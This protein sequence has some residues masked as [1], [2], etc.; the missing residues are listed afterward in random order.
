MVIAYRLSTIRS[1]DLVVALDAGQLLKRR[2]LAGVLRLEPEE[3]RTRGA[4]QLLGVVLEAEQVETFALTGGYLG[5]LAAVELAAATVTLAA[6]ARGRLLVAT[7]AVWVALAVT[8]SR[9]GLRRRR[10]WTETRLALTHDLVERLVGHRTRLA[11][12]GAAIQQLDRERAALAGYA[13][14]SRR[15]DRADAALVAFVPRGWVAAG[16]AALVLPSPAVLDPAGLAIGVGGVLLGWQALR[17]L[18]LGLSQLAGAAVAF[19]RLAPLARA[20]RRPARTSLP[21]AAPRC[22]M[23]AT[24]GSPIPAAPVRCWTV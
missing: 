13:E 7:L 22:W 8:L 5:L 18:T 14:R 17:K 15:L 24:S 9:V 21:G 23:L 19:Q 11:F 6:G 1:A 3:I 20:A 16:A 2:L 12:E 4:G 10:E